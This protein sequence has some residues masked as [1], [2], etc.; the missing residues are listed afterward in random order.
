MAAA[1]GSTWEPV[2]T[3]TDCFPPRQL[4]HSQIY[5]PPLVEE[6]QPG[7]GKLSAPDTPQPASGTVSGS[8]SRLGEGHV[9]ISHTP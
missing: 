6:L 4:L 7:Y 9:G 2:P 3:G 8:V 1:G 5:N